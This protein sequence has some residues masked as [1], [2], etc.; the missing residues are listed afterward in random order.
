MPVWSHKAETDANFEKLTCLLF[1]NIDIV[2]PAF[3]S[4][5]VRS[6]AHAIFQAGRRGIDPRAY[7]FQALYG[8]ADELKS[9]P[10]TAG[11]SRS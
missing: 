9:R 2:T 6:C 7:E 11:S 4:H 10:P 8:M 5:N 3:A 1:D